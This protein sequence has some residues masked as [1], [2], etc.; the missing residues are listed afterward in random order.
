MKLVEAEATGPVEGDDALITP[1]RPPHR[2]VSVSLLFTLTVLVGTVVAIYVSFPARNAVLLTEAVHYHVEAPPVW[3]L[4]SPTPADLRAWAIGVLGKE[5]P[6]P[7]GSAKIL[8][9]REIEVLD[10]RAAVVRLRIGD[11]QVTYL[12][13]QTPVISPEHTE[14]TEG[15]LRATAWRR[16]PFTCVAV[17]PEASSAAWS[18]AMP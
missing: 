15:G 10:R 7:G 2:R 1:P 6:L 12:V 11:D 5:P 18:L 14:I 16:G 17:G 9:A 13:Q 3:S 8:G 4:T